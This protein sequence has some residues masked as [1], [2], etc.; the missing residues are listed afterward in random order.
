ML[1]GADFHLAVV[2]GELAVLV[3]RLDAFDAGSERFEQ[4][5][6][7]VFAHHVRLVIAKVLT[8]WCLDTARGE[9]LSDR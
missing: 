8:V 5:A 3:G 7:E 9:H 6:L 4:L 1:L 2:G